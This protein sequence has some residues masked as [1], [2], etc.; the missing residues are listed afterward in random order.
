MG[1]FRHFRPDNNDKVD[2]RTQNRD[3]Y[4]AV[5]NMKQKSK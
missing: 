3:L 5:G 4:F 2:F 1:Y